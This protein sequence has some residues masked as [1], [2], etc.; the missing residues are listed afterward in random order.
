M[1]DAEQELMGDEGHGVLRWL[2]FAVGRL[3]G[4]VLRHSSSVQQAFLQD[5]PCLV[6]LWLPGD[7]GLACNQTITQLLERVA[8]HVRAFVA[9]AR[10]AGDGMIAVLRELA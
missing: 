9:S 2:R 6:K 5:L 3:A 8:A 7:L 10:D 4:A 1:G